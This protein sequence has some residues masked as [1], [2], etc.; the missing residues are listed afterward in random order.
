MGQLGGR[1]GDGKSRRGEG[2][3]GF[4]FTTPLHN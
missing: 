4:P 2:Y 3:V 1:R